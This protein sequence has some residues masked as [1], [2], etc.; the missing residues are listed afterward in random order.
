VAILDQF[1]EK[2]KSMKEH[3]TE[4]NRIFLPSF[5]LPEEGTLPNQDTNPK[6]WQ[7]TIAT[8]IT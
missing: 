3:R 5:V 2:Q 7:E 6:S 8:G 1:T 4:I